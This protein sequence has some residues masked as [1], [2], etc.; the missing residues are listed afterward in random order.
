MPPRLDQNPLYCLIRLLF[1]PQLPMKRKALS[2]AIISAA[3]LF[4]TNPLA[5]NAS[6]E[7]RIDVIGTGSVDIDVSGEGVNVQRATW[8]GTQPDK[9]SVVSF[10]AGEEWREATFTITPSAN[11]K[12]HIF[13]MGPNEKASTVTGETSPVRIC[14]DKIESEPDSVSIANG[15]FEQGMDGW[16]RVDLERNGV[17]VTDADA[18]R[19]DAGNAAEGNHFANVWHDSR[20]SQSISVYAGEPVTIKFSYRLA[21]P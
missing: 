20:M 6:I 14:Y 3:S 15:S 16:K 9:H 7:G 12:V 17:A 13:L 1:L 5:A 10:S 19:V 18:A 21:T 2:I 8:E 11:G 4:V